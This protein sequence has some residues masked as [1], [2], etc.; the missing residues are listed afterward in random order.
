[1][2]Y[3]DS[4]CWGKTNCTINPEDQ[5]LNLFY[6]FREVCKDRIKFLDI[7]SYDYIVVVGCQE[8]DVQI[9]LIG[10]SIHKHKVGIFVVVMDMISVMFMGLIF[11]KVQNINQ[12][13]LDIM[14]DLRVQMKDFGV[15]FNKVRLDRYTQD[16]LV[17]KMKIWLHMTNVLKEHIIEDND[18]EVIDVT[19]SLYTQP[20]IQ[21]VFRMQEV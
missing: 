9:P 12:E 3:F 21:L 19:L 8:D 14:D 5:D 15:R 1:M 7:T 6:L 18:M 11:S 13:Y 20:S 16:S 2:D 4:H 10:Q 17:Q